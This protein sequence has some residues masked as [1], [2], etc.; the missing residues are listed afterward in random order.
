MMKIDV[1]KLC[2]TPRYQILQNTNIKIS[3]S[4]KKIH[5]ITEILQ[6]L[7]TLLLPHHVLYNSTCTTFLLQATGIVFIKFKLL[8]LQIEKLACF[9]GP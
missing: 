2:Y 4:E 7:V 3:F 5:E 8:K 9:V 1:V 6:F